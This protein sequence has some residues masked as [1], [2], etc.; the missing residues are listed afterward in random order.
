[1]ALAWVG[2]RFVQSLGWAGVVKI[3]SKW[4]SYKSYGT[5]MAAV[6]MSYLF[7]DAIARNFLASLIAGQMSWR[8]IFVVTAAVLGAVLAAC[9]FLL[10]ESPVN[11]GLTEPPANPANVFANE[12]ETATPASLS[13]LL[14][15]LLRSPTFWLVC[16]L[17]AGTTLVREAF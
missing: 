4:F 17:S 11:V 15:P 2:N 16:A 6:S 5:V 13:S 3:A 12:S 10:R 7:G 9:P 1:F 14:Q 8:G